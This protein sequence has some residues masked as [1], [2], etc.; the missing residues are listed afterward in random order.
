MAY[1][2]KLQAT[3]ENNAVDSLSA[4][5][6]LSATDSLGVADDLSAT[7]SLG[8]A[9]DLNTAGTL[10]VVKA[11][12]TAD[13]SDVSR[14]ANA[15]NAAFVKDAGESNGVL[16][17]INKLPKEP[18]TFVLEIGT[19]EIPSAPLYKAT[20]QL[21]A[22][23][24][25]AL[26]EARIEHGEISTWS[27]PRRLIL[28]V[29][30]LALQST[31]LV[32][33]SKGPTVAIAF[34]ANGEPTKA[35]IGFARGK[36]LDVRDLI[37]DKEG[38]IEYVY[39]LVEQ[40]S[41]RTEN[42]LPELLSSLITKIAWHKSQRWGIGEATFSRPVRWLLALW[43][44]AIIPVQFAGLVAGRTTWGHRLMANQPLDVQNASELAS[45]HTRAWVIESAEMRAAHI[46]M[47]IK[48]LEEKHDLKAYVPIDI[49]AEVINLVEFPTTLMGSFDAEFLAV[50]KE[51]IIDAMLKHQRYF[52]LYN[53]DGSLSNHFLVVSNGSPAYNTQIIA[54]HERV[55]RPRLSDAAFFYHE[56]LKRPLEDYVQDLQKVVFH[57][58]L[59]SLYKKVQRITFLSE[60]AC[61]LAGVT[62]SQAK[63]A[64]RA[65]WLC[66]ADLL[67]SAVVEF[68]KLQGVM[69]SYYASAAGDA[70]EVAQA[71]AEHYR[72]R[73]AGDELPAT[74]EGRIVALADK[75]DTICG[76]F[77]AGQGPT[78]SSDPFAL[79]RAAIGIINI[80]LANDDAS[81]N[82][83]LDKLIAIA[84]DALKGVEFNCDKVITQVREFFA[85]RLEVIAKDQG[86]AA[87]AVQAVMATGVLE[88]TDVVAR[89][90]VLSEARQRQPELFAN[91]ATA[92]A[93][94]NNL[95]DPELKGE[96]DESLMGA[97]E[98]A[99]W[100]AICKV[101]EGVA[102]ALEKG[103]YNHA[104]EYL[105]SLR[106]PID[107]FFTEVMIMSEDNRL[108]T[109]RLLLLNR[110]VSVFANVADFAK[111]AG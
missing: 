95:R 50:P 63:N 104:L 81:I 70:P 107:T 62:E 51:I 87:D 74:V 13:A 6:A 52:P 93:R 38:D 47:Q 83:S 44:E 111:L 27:T 14:E 41:K 54:G 22:L 26:T 71:I 5:D 32:Q 56:D 28:E 103:Q 61:E 31:P 100:A 45:A 1:S 25:E 23:A 106:N 30:R 39:A 57:E 96:L 58:K 89:L 49:L 110:F 10:G 99:L 79:R 78:G 7:D 67:T 20:E 9:D 34:D 19:E 84:I 48:A 8:V 75:I 37:R 21:A 12:D 33:K 109:N 77:A 4:T 66:K 91:L 72:P 65:A 85:T 101:S 59:G 92:Y 97:P 42:I 69:G 60:Q 53:A 46:K 36:G 43:G 82:V 16:L 17:D 18:T 11:A 80:L 29:K 15:A 3:S 94:A 35:A 40:H 90:A 105:A 68:T 76:I 88:P 24:K 86:F 64:R 73:F 108:R 55:V 98:Q 2:E 102:A